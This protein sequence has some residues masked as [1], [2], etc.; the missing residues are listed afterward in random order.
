MTQQHRVWG[1]PSMLQGVATTLALIVGSSLAKEDNSAEPVLTDFDEWVAPKLG[2]NVTEKE[3]L[4]EEVWVK[5]VVWEAM[6]TTAWMDYITRLNRD[7]ALYGVTLEPLELALL[8]GQETL[9]LERSILGYQVSM[10][11]RDLQLEGLSGLSLKNLSLSRDR[12]LTSIFTEAILD[13]PYLL[14][15]G[16]YNM[17]GTAKESLLSYLLPDI[18]SEGDQEFSINITRARIRADLQVELVGGCDETGNVS[19]VV[20]KIEF[21]FSYRDLE[22]KFDNLGSTVAAAVEGLGGWVIEYQRSLLVNLIR[23]YI[24]SEVATFVCSSYERVGIDRSIVDTEDWESPIWRDSR[25]KYL[26]TLEEKPLIRDRLAESTV[27]TIFEET[28]MRH[29]ATRGSQLRTQ[30]DPLPLFP[31]EFG[32]KKDVYSAD[33][34]ACDAYIHNIKTAK[35]DSMFLARDP[36]LEY[37]ALRVQ[38]SLPITWVTGFYKLRNAYLFT[39]IPA[40]GSGDF[41]VDLKDVRV[42]LAVILRH[43]EELGLQMEHFRVDIGWQTIVFKFDGLWS[44]LEEIADKVMN[45]FG[46]GNVLVA[47]QKQ[48]IMSEIK[49]YVRGLA[50]CMMWS[51]SQ[52]IDLCMRDFWI[53]LGWEWP[54]VY[55]TCK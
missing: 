29:L 42:S 51:P 10:S 1:S 6:V 34:E 55:P 18:S 23:E 3:S 24:G 47:K 17:E 27:S 26:L 54:W 11:L 8:T 46:L 4:V 32:F 36:S 5:D 19:P 44:G 39:F 25:F 35:F 22:F 53:G 41:N 31:I 21:P 50:V 2:I 49:T 33:V 30:L 38:F 40:G 7:K 45:Q 28:I 15:T 48:Y 43:T 9:A 12:N 37:S 16:I 52:G 13:A 20:T 14:L